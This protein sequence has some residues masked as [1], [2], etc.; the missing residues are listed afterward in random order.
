MK[1][2][3][4]VPERKFR[5]LGRHRT[6]DTSY[7]F[8]MTAG[9]A[10]DISRAHPASIQPCLGDPTNFPTAYGQ[11]VVVDSVSEG[12]RPIGAGDSALTQIWGVTCRPY[13]IQQS[14]TSNNYGEV[15]YGSIAPPLLQPID[16][17]TVGYMM[18]PVVGAPI[19]G[20]SVWIW[21]AAS[22]GGHTQGGFEAANTGGST[23]ALNGNYAWNSPP[24]TNGIAE[25]KIVV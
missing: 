6:C 2:N 10:G 18:V 13:P 4:L 1:D 5:V 15:N 3:I 20:G 17:M 9:A 16:V 12:V 24:D 11:P 21:Y 23:L 25:L 7:T 19:K 8:R 22:G 14:T